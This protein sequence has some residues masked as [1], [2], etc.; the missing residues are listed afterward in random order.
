MISTA[1]TD[2]EIEKWLDYHFDPYSGELLGGND[3][4][5]DEFNQWMM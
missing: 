1:L 4:Y 5:D 2:I 3:E